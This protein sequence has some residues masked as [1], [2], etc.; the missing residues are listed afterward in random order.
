MKWKA[1][2]FT[3]LQNAHSL[4]RGLGSARLLHI[5]WVWED[6]FLYINGMRYRWHSLEHVKHVNYNYIFKLSFWACKKLAIILIMVTS[7]FLFLGMQVFR[8]ICMNTEVKIT[9]TDC[10][11]NRQ[12]CSVNIVWSSN[13]VSVQMSTQPTPFTVC[14]HIYEE[15]K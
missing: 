1:S 7:Y 12:R 6:R 2:M 9:F 15:G 14:G 13:L 5:A 10:L 3:C 4:W 8:K 11:K